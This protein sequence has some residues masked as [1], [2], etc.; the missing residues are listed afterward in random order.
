VHLLL[1]CV[2]A[3]SVWATCRRWWDKEDRL[4]T[5]MTAFVDWLRS[6][7]RRKDDLCDFWIGIALVCWCLWRHRNYIVFEGATPS[8]GSVIR[9]ILA[10]TEV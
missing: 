4:P 3:R 2:L 8:V 7:H 5:Q 10:E 9:K 6:W 1:G